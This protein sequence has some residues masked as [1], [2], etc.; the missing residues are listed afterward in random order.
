VLI[1]AERHARSALPVEPLVNNI[2]RSATGTA[3]AGS[4]EVLRWPLV[5]NARVSQTAEDARNSLQTWLLA[6]LAR[7]PVSLLW[8]M[9]SAAARHFLSEDA[10]E[11]LWQLVELE[12]FQAKALI[13]PD[14]VTLLQ[15]PLLKRQLWMALQPLL[16]V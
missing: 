3:I 4:E 6:E 15:Q 5:E 11:C 1:L 7:R 10:D 13:T 9:G 8:L 14:P 12:A 2:L 16:S